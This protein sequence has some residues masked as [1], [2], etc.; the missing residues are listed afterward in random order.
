MMEIVIKGPGEF[1]F[2]LVDSR[3][4][5]LMRK[6]LVISGPRKVEA[7]SQLPLTLQTRHAEVP[8]V[9]V[10]VRSAARSVVTFAGK[11]HAV[12]TGRRCKE[13]GLAQAM[14]RKAAK[15]ATELGER[16]GI[17]LSLTGKADSRE[18]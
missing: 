6:R 17:H 8:V 15:A 3:G 18:P 10:L 11:K 14:V 13:L 12:Y 9:P 4:T 7:K 5:V 2:G 16:R 1:I